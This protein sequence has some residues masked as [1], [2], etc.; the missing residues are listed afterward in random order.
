MESNNYGENS[1]VIA[2]E[3]NGPVEIN[4]HYHEKKRR[5]PSLLPQFIERL[6]NL[7]NVQEETEN[8]HLNTQS[9]DIEE[10][11]EHNHLI[12]YK[13]IVEDYGSYYYTCEKAFEYI[14][15]NNYG[16][17]KRILRNISEIYKEI[18]R[19]L[20]IENDPTIVLID[21]I[22][23][24][25]DKIINQVKKEIKIRFEVSYTTENIFDDDLDFCLSV[26]V[27]YAFCECKILERPKKLC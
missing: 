5:L 18:K 22:R 19:S 7:V 13:D 25:S 20:I 6:A 3:I 12:A 9:Y 24:N 26:F 2:G 21:L 1:G 8:G 15:S 14:D 27:C 4:Q 10:K 11:I 23:I 16:S 17:K